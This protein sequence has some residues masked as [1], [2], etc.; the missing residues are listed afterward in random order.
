MVA[1]LVETVVHCPAG[2]STVNIHVGFSQYVCVIHHHKA[3]ALVSMLMMI[4]SDYG[5]LGADTD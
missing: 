4:I 1:F 3:G 5:K 2:L